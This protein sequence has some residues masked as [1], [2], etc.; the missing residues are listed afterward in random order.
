MFRIIQNPMI[1]NYANTIFDEFDIETGSQTDAN[2]FYN[3]YFHLQWQLLLILIRVDIR[4]N[5]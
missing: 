3:Y 4:L 1:Y 5:L 2:S